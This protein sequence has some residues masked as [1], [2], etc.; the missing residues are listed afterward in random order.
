ME[1]ICKEKSRG[2]HRTQKYEKFSHFLEIELPNYFEERILPA[3]DVLLAAMAKVHSLKL[4]TRNTKDF[5]NAS[6]ELINS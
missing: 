5:V 3:I 4:V 6:V 1:D 2:N